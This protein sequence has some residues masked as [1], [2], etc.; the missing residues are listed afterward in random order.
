M[1]LKPTDFKNDEIV[2]SAFSPGGTS[3]YPDS[4]IMSA[5]L[6]TAIIIQSELAIVILQDCRKSFPVIQQ[7]SA[8]H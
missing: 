5:T 2:L 7:D 1:I 6:A 4:D 8:I 3:L